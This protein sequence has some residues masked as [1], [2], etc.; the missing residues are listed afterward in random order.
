MRSSGNGD[1]FSD[2]SKDDA[3]DN[4]EKVLD[5]NRESEIR[6]R[7]SSIRNSTTKVKGDE[8]DDSFSSCFFLSQS[9]LSFD[10][11]HNREL[12]CSFHLCHTHNNAFPSG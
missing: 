8:L 7:P 2:S 11:N 9:F 10:E 6:S 4:V 1:S 5:P 12:R 3:N